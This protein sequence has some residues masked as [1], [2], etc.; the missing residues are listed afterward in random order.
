M[1]NKSSNYKQKMISK[2]L[3]RNKLLEK[4]KDLNEKTGMIIIGGK[5]G[6]RYNTDTE[7]QF[8]QDSNCKILKN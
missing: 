4:F 3:I 7:L 8:R 2:K 6:C 1:K 5:S